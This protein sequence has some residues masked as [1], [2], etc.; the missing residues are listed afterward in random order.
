M[1]VFCL[2]SAVQTL[3]FVSLLFLSTNFYLYLA[4]PSLVRHQDMGDISYKCG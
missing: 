1:G 4:C 3:L 2:S